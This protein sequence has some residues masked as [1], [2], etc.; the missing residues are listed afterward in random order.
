[1]VRRSLKLLLWIVS[2]GFIASVVIVLLLRWVDPPTSSFMLQARLAAED[3][4]FRLRHEWVDSDRLSPHLKL[5]VIAA[6]DQLF[7][8]HWGFDVQSINKAWEERQRGK[9]VRGAST[10]SQQVAKNLFL[11]SGRSWL[12]KGLESYLTVLIETLWPKRRI[13]E[14]YLNVAEFGKGIYGAEAAAQR[15]F[16]KPAARLSSAEAALMAAVLP[17]PIRMKVS[18]PSRYVRT[19]QD[20]ILRQMRSLGGTGYLQE[21]EDAPPQRSARS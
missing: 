1:L 16:R 8:R 2:G 15:F 4:D 14:V 10:L 18:A 7:P 3:A 11:W 12:R 6:E 9:R 17:N 20:W 13:L 21:L 5:A 19:R